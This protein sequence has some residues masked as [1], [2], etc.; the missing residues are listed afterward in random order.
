MKNKTVKVYIA[1]N[2]VE[3]ISK[4]ADNANKSEASKGMT[5]TKMIYKLLEF[6]LA[7]HGKV[8]EDSDTK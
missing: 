1:K 8:C 6:S 2:Q 7:S 5:L 3:E 4:L